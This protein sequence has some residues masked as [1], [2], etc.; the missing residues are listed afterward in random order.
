MKL[1]DLI[2][3]ANFVELNFPVNWVRPALVLAFLCAVVVVIVFVYVDRYWKKPYFSLWKISWMS[4]A[5]WLAVTV[6][7]GEKPDMP[8]L[9][10]VQRACIGISALFM[11]W[12][13]F[14][15]TGTPMA[16]RR[17]L[18]WGVMLILAWSYVAAYQVGDHLWMTMPVFFLLA[19][20]SLYTA[21]LHG[22]RR[23][24]D[25]GMR[26]LADGFMLWGVHLFIY[27]LANSL[28]VTVLTLCYFASSGL[29][30]FIALGMLVQVLE[31]LRVQN[32][33][34]SEEFKKNIA[35]RRLLEQEMALT[36]EKYR[37][38]FQ[39]ASDAI[40]IVDLQTLEILE[41]NQAAAHF[42]GPSTDQSVRRS[43][44]DLCPNV[45]LCGDNSLLNKKL[46]E[47]VIKPSTEFLLLRPGGTY[48]PCEGSASLLQFNKRPAMQISVRE[49]TE[50]KHLEQQLRQSE[51][52]SALG[53]L[54]A[55]VAHE[56]N[57]PL[58]VI[59]GYAQLIGKQDDCQP[60]F[61][62]DLQKIIHESER[63]AK[64]VRNL[65]TFARP[66]EPQMTTVDLN[67]LVN[68][69]VSTH[70]EELTT[71]GI[72]VKSRLAA[73][74]PKTIA[75]PH[76]IEQVLTNLVTNAAHAVTGKED[77]PREIEI[78]SEVK[79]RKLRITV[80]DSGPGVPPEIISKIFDPFFTTKSP[81]KGTGLG[82]SI[83]HSIMEEHRGRI[84]VQNEPGK[85]AK[86]CIELPL[87][88]RTTEEQ[89]ADDSDHVPELP[90]DPRAAYRRVLVV[91]DEPGIID[92]FITMLGSKGYTVDTAAD[93]QQALGKI[94]N[95]H[96]DLIISDLCMPG[97]DG[98]G[99]HKAIRESDPELANRILFVTGDTISSHSR[100]FLEWS[101]N[102][103]CS[104]PFNI[105]ELEELVRNFLSTEPASVA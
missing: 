97:L 8:Y 79:D 74:L 43:F 54:V 49:I 102:R 59:M 2:L 9:V 81:G 100:S 13:S 52:L 45:T 69:V 103:W 4:Y 44:Q 65:L 90:P 82:L 31:S 84:W 42:L 72:Q 104:K 80:A 85:G 48:V 71:G 76:Q 53:Q 23:K 20:A 96:Y 50:R 14:E 94:A 63:A 57:N 30:L 37:A 38:L 35:S 64:I 5:V 68:N 56:L 66:R 16:R 27:P 75:D 46:I 47:E 105:R 86:F 89:P 88:V 87:I 7:I 98:E 95:H 41:S 70:Q 10:M 40:F 15:L 39:A 67:R 3:I 61:K 99:L 51:K 12:G 91:D 60:K 29:A 25:R 73:D 62:G 28:P 92:V 55:G 36:E 6:E 32:E 24:Q 33:D 11:F 83:S 93:G 21:Y 78:S 34:L 101:G 1:T 77:G 17:E 26:L 18:T 22:R 58:A 19:V